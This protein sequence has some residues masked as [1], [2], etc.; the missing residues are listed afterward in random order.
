MEIRDLVQELLV[1]L[2]GLGLEKL[3][4]LLQAG[5]L[6]LPERSLHLLVDLVNQIDVDCEMAV[7][8]DFGEKGM[9]EV[10]FIASK[11]EGLGV[12]QSNQIR[13]CE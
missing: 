13:S 6:Q 2:V 12:L 7:I 3:N 10:D 9:L 4:V 11:I 5:S 1:V 8:H